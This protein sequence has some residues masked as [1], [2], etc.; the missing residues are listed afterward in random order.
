M[1][2]ACVRC[3]GEALKASADSHP[4]A[5][6]TDPRNADRVRQ[7]DARYCVTCH[8]EH[9]PE[10]VS[11]M[12]LSLPKDYCFRCHEDVGR[13]RPS[14]QGLG[15]DSCATAGCHNFHDN[16]GL[17]EDFLAK[18]LDE[19]AAKPDGRNLAR[20]SADPQRE[21]ELG[22][23]QRAAPFELPEPELSAFKASA[24]ARARVECSDCHENRET[25]AWTKE[26]P[27]ERCSDDCHRGERKG[28]LEGRH[29][30][31]QAVGLDA[32]QVALARR[33]MVVGAAERKV[34]CT[35]CH[36]S[37]AFDTRQAAVQACLGCHADPHSLAYRKSPHAR[38]WL[39]D[40][41]GRSGASCATCHL[42]RVVAGGR[43]TVDHNQNANLRPNEKMVR[44][45]C[46]SCHGVQFTL[47][48]LADTNLIASNF[49]R[50]PSPLSP[51]PLE[52][53]RARLTTTH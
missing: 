52:M 13:E 43:V 26:V 38:A 10:L 11:T 28:F 45:L 3:H 48:A 51:D 19:P 32:M 41:S 8:R 20:A 25:R 12:G 39:E 9:R 34:G 17:Y 44:G 47:A 29:G 4:E 7:L 2:E 6:F 24:H 40:E 46:D 1:Q 18:H 37:H 35:S 42:P 30:M 15:F 49:D 53:V 27:D 50:Q 21:P 31:R 36:S 16:R 5:K 33:V 14:H 22:E 23:A